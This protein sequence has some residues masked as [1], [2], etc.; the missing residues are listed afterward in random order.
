MNSTFLLPGVEKRLQDRYQ[1]LVQEHT[2]QAHATAAGP[3][4][5]P[6]AAHAKAHAQ[7]AWRFFR[8]P[9]LSLPQLMH[10]LLELARQQ[11]DHACSAYAL[12]VHDWSGLNYSSHAGKHDKIVLPK[13]RGTGYELYAALLL[14]DRAGQPLAPLR[15]R[16][17]GRDGLYDSACRPRRPPPV[18]LDGLLAVLRQLRALQLP[19]PLVHLIDAEGDS[20][21][22]LRQWQRDG[23]LFLVRTDDQ[24]VVRH[25]GVERQLPALVELLRRRR[26]FRYTRV[27]NYQGRRAQQYV[28]ET[29]II[30]ERPSWRHRT[31]DGQRKRLVRV[32]APLPLRLVVSEVRAADGQV[33]AR[34]QLLTNVPAAV[35]AAT[36]A[37]WYYWRWQVESYFKLLKAAGQQLEHWQQENAGAIVRRLLVASMACALVWRL[38]RSA[39]PAAASARRL[40]MQLSGRQVVWGKEFSEEAMLAGLWVLLAMV[41]AL[42]ERLPEELQQMA[43]FIMAGSDTG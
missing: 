9:S 14:G 33:L 23:H 8:N 39:A 4:L 27:V 18:H 16:L 31:I 12:T 35:D 5:L 40:L 15:I 7:A 42:Q 28:A 20:V 10:P 19:R 24:R 21:Y 36:V 22:H 2:G 30:L 11:T 37:L 38:A 13:G 1:L 26:A 29:A 34:W 3:R 32:G 6:T 41:A 17:R 43:D 25:E